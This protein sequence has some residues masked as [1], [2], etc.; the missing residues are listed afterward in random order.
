MKKHRKLSFG[1][2][3]NEFVRNPTE[4]QPPW[5]RTKHDLQ[6]PSVFTKHKFRL[7][8]QIYLIN[9][10]ILNALRQANATRASDFGNLKVIAPSPIILIRVRAQEGQF[11]SRPI[12]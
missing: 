3:D 6:E 8:S 4:K 10:N 9:L 1:Q 2:T 12:E 5:Q 7:N 11:L